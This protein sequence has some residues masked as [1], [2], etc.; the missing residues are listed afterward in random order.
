MSRCR[1]QPSRVTSTQT[2]A[3]IYSSSFSVFKAKYFL[4]ITLSYKCA[5]VSNRHNYYNQQRSGF[6]RE[7]KTPEAK[8]E[9]VTQQTK[10]SPPE[11]GTSGTPPHPK[12]RV[13]TLFR[14]LM[15]T[16]GVGCVHFY[17]NI[18]SMKT[19]KAQ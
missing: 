8:K 7:A 11:A 13:P 12:L 6:R 10:P 4:Q 3:E 19:Y 2:P 1:A 9:S 17:N 18:Y 5:F 16:V 15:F 14:P